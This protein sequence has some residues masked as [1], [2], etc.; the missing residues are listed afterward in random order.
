M[1][2]T[3][4][5]VVRQAARGDLELVAFGVIETPAGA[6]AGARLLQLEAGIERVLDAYRPTSA[7]VERLFFERNVSTAMSV[8]QARG[9]ALLTLARR[10]I[11]IS[12]YSPV[13]VKQAVAGYGAADKQQMQTMVQALLRMDHLPRPD[14]A[15]DALA[16]AICHAHSRKMAAG[17]AKQAAEASATSSMRAERA[18]R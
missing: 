15:A 12:E 11:P 7:G 5:G 6:E 8:G 16:V 9:V 3:G 2:R 1:A 4:Y 17:L 10:A 14:D 18:R 13:E